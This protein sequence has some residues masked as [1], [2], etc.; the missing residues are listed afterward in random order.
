[1]KSR[2]FLSVLLLSL[3]CVAPALAG[4]V[5]PPEAKAKNPS[6]K[7]INQTKLLI[8]VLAEQGDVDAQFKLGVKYYYGQGVPQ[9]YA[10][11]AKWFR[12]AADQGHVE[13]RCVLGMCYELGQGVEQDQQ[14]AKRF[15]Q[16]ACLPR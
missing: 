1:M 4:E 15:Y 7:V 5:K 14:E 10:Q 3:V 6:K 9:D 8:E 11:A 12:K 13:A 16:L 2:L